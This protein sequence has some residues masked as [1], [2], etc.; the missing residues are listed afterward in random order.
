[1]LAAHH[2]IMSVHGMVLCLIMVL[3]LNGRIGGIHIISNGLKQIDNNSC[4]PYKIHNDFA[5]AHF[6]SAPRSKRFV[7]LAYSCFYQ[8]PVSS[9]C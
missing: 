5:A 6:V 3:S 4:Y 8:R 2:Q 9:C 1:M 7:C